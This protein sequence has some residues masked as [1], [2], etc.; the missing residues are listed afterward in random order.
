[1]HTDPI[2]KKPLYHFHPGS[3]AFSLATAGCNMNC[4]YCQNWEISQVRPEQVRSYAMTA[5]DCVAQA[6]RTRA[7]S[8]AYTYTEPVIFWEYMQDIAAAARSEG[9]S[10]VMISAGY[11]EQPPL[12]DLLPLMD[13]VKIDLKAFSEDYY[14]KVCRG[15]LKPVLETLK[16]IKKNG[17]W[18]EIVYLVLPTMN[19]GS[20][21]ITSLCSWIR[22]ELGPE[23]PIHFTR[24]HPVYLMKN[25]PPTPVSTLER[26]HRIARA[27]GLLFPYVGNVP[28]HPAENTYCPGCGKRLIHRTGYNVRVEA[29][30]DGK[31][32]GCGMEIPG[33][34][35]P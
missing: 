30:R 2:E 16:T 10:S 20:K 29:L 5:G 34:W 22:E 1:M 6:R 21:E 26:H 3:R 33:V 4:K 17:V 31:C 25:L 23:V 32:A 27:Q 11:V 8:I 19:D 15:E 9:I 28:G 7:R 35:G 14:R 24:F 12:R 18:L 13:A